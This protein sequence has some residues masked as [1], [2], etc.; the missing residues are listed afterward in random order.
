MHC[1]HRLCLGS[2]STEHT[3][4]TIVGQRWFPFYTCN[5][6]LCLLKE[7][8][9]CFC[10]SLG[11]GEQSDLRPAPPSPSQSPG[12]WFTEGSGSGERGKCPCA[13]A[14]AALFSAS[15]SWG[16]GG[17]GQGPA[18]LLGVTGG[19]GH[20]RFPKKP[21]FRGR[22]KTQAKMGWRNFDGVSC[23]TPGR[24]GADPKPNPKLRCTPPGGGGEGWGKGKQPV[25]HSA[26]KRCH[27]P[28]LW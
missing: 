3:A 17:G 28:G 23:F 5:L 26:R 11:R 15:T 14:S 7:K 19:Q 24:V 1:K 25:N 12:R 27:P 10:D 4:E 6:F 9:V 22:P 8:P 20:F 13:R 18:P 16:Q 2:L 21:T